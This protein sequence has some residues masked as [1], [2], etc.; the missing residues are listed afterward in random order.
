MTHSAGLGSSWGEKMELLP[1]IT[2][3]LVAAGA[4]VLAGMTGFGYALLST[5]LLLALGYPP[6]VVVTT[7]LSI[8]LVTRTTVAWRLRSWVTWR[9]V[10]LLV[11]GSLPGLALGARLQAVLDPDTMRPAIGIAVVIAAL[12]MLRARPQPAG[13]GQRE[14]T[15][16]QLSTGLL[17]G[18]LGTT[19]SLSGVPLIF[20][21][22]RLGL[23]PVRFIGDLAVYFVLTNAAGLLLLVLNRALAPAA[24]LT[25]TVIWLPGALVGTWAG[26]RLGARLPALHFRRLVLAAA[27]GAGSLTVVAALLR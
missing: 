12:L 4:A 23:K 5:P 3:G 1:T 8:A 18:I 17:S 11:A 26:V 24:L 7:N 27:L 22:S 19:T 10:G 15:V 25:T 14:G 6:A 2:G 9:R 21:L 16:L 13:H 20:Y